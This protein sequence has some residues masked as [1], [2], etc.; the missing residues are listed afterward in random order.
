MV[1]LYDDSISGYGNVRAWL[2]RV[3]SQPGHVAM[4]AG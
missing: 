3:K 1:T 2:D 4:A